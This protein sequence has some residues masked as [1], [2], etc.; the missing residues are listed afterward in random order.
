MS[1]WL[2]GRRV[3]VTRPE[4]QAEGL[5]SRLRALGAEPVE[6]PVIAIAPPETGGPL[7]Q[8]IARLSS[9]DWLIFTSVNGVEY[10]WARLEALEALAAG[11]AQFAAAKV[12]AIGPAKVAAIGP[13]TATA[14]RQRGVQVCLVPAEYRAEAIL[15]E[16]GDVAGQTILLPRADI[17]RPALA[18]GLRGKGAQVDEVPAYRTVPAI[19]A[20]AAFDA[21]RAGVDVITFTSSS[22]V[23]SF[24]AQTAGLSYGDPRVACIGPVTATTA[25][26]L[27][28][29][30]DVVAKEY[31][32]D[33]LLEA[34]DAWSGE[35][36]A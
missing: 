15:D 22:T 17:A 16:I 4:E 21:L 27:G 8:A 30:V 12:A 33:G 29:R 24:V 10:F 5:C 13:A 11:P 14:L 6:F 23:H 31:T 7:D 9:Y 26:E 19:P 36:E 28:L 1:H 25:R 2:S 18:D 35:R 34:L 32:I 3:V 20:A